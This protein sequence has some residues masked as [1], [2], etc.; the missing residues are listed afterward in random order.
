MIIE[1]SNYNGLT[2][3]EVS[4]KHEQEGYNEL[5]SS[6]SKS[7]WRIALG[8]LKEPM[9]FYWLLAEHCTGAGRH[10]RRYYVDGVCARHHGNRVFQ[11]RK[12]EK[13]L[14]ALKDLASPRAV[15]IRNGEE[16]RIAGR[17][18][19]SGDIIVLREGDR[20]PADAT[21]LSCVNLL[22]DESLL[23]G[24]SVPV[25]KAEFT[26]IEVDTH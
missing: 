26:G 20:V 24:E 15:V 11:E 8:I 14:D 2:D 25:H 12:T 1:N 3:E 4:R 5:P 22:V 13:A 9:L 23:T 16:Q 17:D 7:I 21:V 10:S 18:V 19:V 6:K